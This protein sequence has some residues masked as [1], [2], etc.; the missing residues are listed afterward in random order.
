[1]ECIK[2]HRNRPGREFTVY[3]GLERI[4]SHQYSS[5]GIQGYAGSGWSSRT[6]YSHLVQGVETHHICYACAAEF[7]D[8]IVLPFR[9]LMPITLALWLGGWLWQSVGEQLNDPWL[10]IYIVA[11]ALCSLLT[12]LAGLL[13]L[14][15]HGWLR[16]RDQIDRYLRSKRHI[17][18]RQ[19][20]IEVWLGELIGHK[21]ALFSAREYRSMFNRS[22]LTFGDKFALFWKPWM[23]W[24]LVAV[25]LFVIFFATL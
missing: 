20:M 22:K 18:S 25:L 23:E 7:Y 19:D 4:L 14:Y 9:I 3:Y 10:T 8:L 2:C 12:L 1:M 15:R 16:K 13:A 5:W 17:F 11:T 21:D 24:L 6:E